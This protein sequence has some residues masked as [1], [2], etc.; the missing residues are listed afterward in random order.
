MTT[1]TKN[2][3]VYYEVCDVCGKECTALYSRQV[4]NQMQI[5]QLTHKKTKGELEGE[6]SVKSEDLPLN[7]NSDDEAMKDE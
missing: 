6:D 2:K 3:A 7:S 4:M 5:H 1:K